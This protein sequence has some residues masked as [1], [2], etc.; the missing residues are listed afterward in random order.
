MKSKVD[1]QEY[2]NEEEVCGQCGRALVPTRKGLICPKC[3]KNN[4]KKRS[5][6]V[7]IQREEW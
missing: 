6:P 5:K 7:R 1:W 4:D 2:D 3:D